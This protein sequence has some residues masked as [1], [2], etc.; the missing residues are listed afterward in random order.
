[1]S[2]NPAR[3]S[4]SKELSAASTSAA[5]S[6]RDLERFGDYAENHPPGFS[7]LITALE[8]QA[9]AID[10]LVNAVTALGIAVN[11]EAIRPEDVSRVMANAL[12]E[13]ALDLLETTGR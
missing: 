4:I 9:R 8:F 2:G 10:Q 13:A 3:V 6:R 11:A 5:G 12:R 1:M 7:H